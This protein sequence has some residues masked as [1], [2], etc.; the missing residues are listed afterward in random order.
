MG[1][2]S[3]LTITSVLVTTPAHR[4]LDRP[5]LCVS[6]DGA[7]AAVVERARVVVVELATGTTVSEIA[8]DT[9]AEDFEVAWLGTP[10]R[11]LVL[12]RH[13]AHSTA[14]LVDVQESRSIAEIRLQTPMRLFTAVGAHAL[15][16]G[17]QSAAVLTAGE[18][19][20]TPYQFPTRT[21]PNVA[22]AA[23]AQFVVALPGVI[24]EWDPH[25]RMPKRRLR[26][27]RPVTI[28]ALGGSDRVV[29]MVAQQD[30]SRIEVLPLIN[31]GQPKVHDLPEPIAA[32]TG[33]PR[34][35]VI[36]CIGAETGRLYVIDL[37]GRTRLRVVAPHGLDHVEAAALVV[38]RTLGLLAA[39][40]GR[41]IVVV[42]L[43]GREPEVATITAI[44][45]AIAG[46]AIPAPA[47][48]AP[49]PASAEELDDELPRPSSLVEEPEPPL[50]P[51]VKERTTPA[52]FPPSLRITDPDA[53]SSVHAAASGSGPVPRTK[54]A[55]RFAAVRERRLASLGAPQPVQSAAVAVAVAVQSGAVPSRSAAAPLKIPRRTA[56]RPAW[57]D[58]CVAWARSAIAG[59]LETPPPVIP[60]LDA[61]A[62]EHGLS[63]E[64]VPALVLLYGAHLA[65]EPGVA[66]VDVARILGGRWDE[67]LARGELAARGVIELERSRVRFVAAVERD[68]DD[69]P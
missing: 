24:E 42:P 5:R 52:A 13:D 6:A 7:L 62:A 38:G 61:L 1:H 59:T 65:G 32:V 37:D 20:V 51:E 40:Q 69:Q 35:D 53:P 58:D 41:P 48:A 49:E 57:R 55:E 30:P 66:P 27:P 50:A 18:S 63:P 47:I 44:A 14:H 33:H 4:P 45:T 64:L 31:R 60:V 23:A 8:A 39:Q 68:L 9:L 56:P 28:S 29:W 43:D 26:M 22:G 11:L 34:S 3:Q 10:P 54:L 67:A 2:A 19:H 25:S 21:R 46:P 15:V 36:A 17:A 12:A 16:I